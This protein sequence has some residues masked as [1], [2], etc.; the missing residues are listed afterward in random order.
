MSAKKTPSLDSP[1]CPAPAQP[2]RRRLAGPVL[3][4]LAATAAA[5]WTI[6]PA[7]G[8]PG[9]TCDEP[10]HV[11]YGKR[12]VTAWRTQGLEFFLAANIA[13]NFHWEQDRPDAPPVHPPLG[14]WLLGW[15]NHWFEPSADH[16]QP[17]AIS[18]VGPRFVPAAA[19][20]LLVFIVGL[21]TLRMAGPLAGTVAAA[22]VFLVPR[23]FGHAHLAAL[24]M[25]T[26]FWFVAAILAAIEAHARGGRWWHYS[27]AG[28]VWGLAM[29]TRLSG[30]LVAPPVVVWMI[31]RLRHRAI[32]P[33]LTWGLAGAGTLF[34][35]WPW[36]WLDPIGHTMRFL[37]TGIN[38]QSIK[39][40]YAGTVW[41][42]ATD[43]QA[44]WHY[45]PVMFAVALPLGLL[46]L[47]LLGLWAVVRRQLSVGSCRL[48]VIS[49]RR[50]LS[51]DNCQPTTANCQLSTDNCQLT[52]AYWLV[53]GSLALVLIASSWPGRPI[54][55]GVRLFLMVFPLWAISVGIGAKW[56]VE[57]RAWSRWSYVARVGVVAAAVAAQGIGLILYHPC[58][59][60]HYS[61]L[62]GGLPGAQR[63][64][65]EVTY[66]G[67]SVTED[68]LQEAARRAEGQ[69]VLFGPNLAPYQAPYV[70]FLSPALNRSQSFLVG[71]NKEDPR[72]RESAQNCRYAVIYRR[73]ANLADLPEPILNGPVVAEK[74]IL[75]VWLARVIESP[76]FRGTVFAQTTP[77]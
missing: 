59:L 6:D 64:G 51:T 33:L 66:W 30:V 68:L 56:L 14:H 62:V 5:F 2:D 74:A 18:I 16:D 15:M 19:F 11:G 41:G 12:L 43:H 39:V 76:L 1:A 50:Q 4:A 17:A 8:G 67:D 75:G 46:A 10:Y 61:L 54:Y 52:T 53:M 72:V 70:G 60:S 58:Y 7:R 24:D 28:V 65:F 69:S 77:R 31:W 44:P 20:G 37:A 71:W 55:D 63:L 21:A 34:A 22:G 29:L 23:V 38:R 26:T 48:S 35:S 3:V 32:V 42:D 25:L 40:F 27:M 57:H 47:G 36:L 13:K 45:A 49:G 73:E 9:V